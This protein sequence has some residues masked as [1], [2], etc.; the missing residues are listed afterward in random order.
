MKLART[1]CVLGPTASGKTALALALAEELN[2]E[3]IS[4]DSALVYRGMDI[5]T[6]KPTPQ[7]RARIPHH[8]IDLLDPEEAYTAG[9][10]VQDA[11]AAIAAIQARGRV[12]LLAGGTMLYAKALHEGIAA[13]PSADAALRAEI[14]AYAQTHGWPAV[15]AWLARLDPQT[16]ARLSPND[17]Q[18]LQRALEVVLTT[19]QP[20]ETLWQRQPQP[21]T[22]L[23]V[24]ALLPAEA[25]WLNARIEARFDAMLRAGFLEEVAALRARPHL[26]A[27]HPSMRAVGYRQAWA[28]L[29]GKLTRDE[30]IA[31]AIAAT[32]QLAKRQRT[33]LRQ[34]RE[35]WSDV[36]ILDPA[37]PQ[38][39]A[40]ARAWL[41]R[42]VEPT[43]PCPCATTR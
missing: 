7:E 5:G 33:W 36:T 39:E 43:G 29:E 9:R 40:K 6:A 37:D 2:A 23:A 34:F 27:E 11:R 41:A 31:Q 35:R 3:V 18:R 8:L 14:D 28:H 22:P 26:S 24:L 15:H 17:R 32:R 13:L 4:V 30:M 25:H 21:G 16:A 12:P 10:F 19:G 42:A 20:L 38:L 1:P